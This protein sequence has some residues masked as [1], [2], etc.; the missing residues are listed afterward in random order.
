MLKVVVPNVAAAVLIRL[1]PPLEHRN[2]FHLVSAPGAVATVNRADTVVGYVLG[3][4]STSW[5]LPAGMKLE[6]H[7]PLKVLA[8]SETGAFNAVVAGQPSR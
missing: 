8:E 3:E 5:Q 2:F 4:S 6:R 1:P 7:T